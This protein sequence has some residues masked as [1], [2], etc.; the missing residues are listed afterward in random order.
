MFL[1][2]IKIKQVKLFS[3]FF[4]GILLFQKNM[5][6]L[7]KILKLLKNYKKE[8]VIAI[9]SLL[10]VSLCTSAIAFLVKPVLDDIFINKN[11]NMLY[12]I[13]VVVIIL[14]A[15][16]GI[17]DFT[18]TYMIGFICQKIV[19]DI[20]QQ[21]FS[22]IVNL[23]ME[24]FT[25]NSTGSII[26]RLL[27]DVALIQNT[28][29]NAITGVIKD[30]F[31]VISLIGVAFYRDAVLGSIALYIL[32]L[33]VLPVIK[34]GKKSKNVS[35]KGQEQAGS[36]TT[37]AHEIVTG[38][39][40]VKA[41]NM[42]DYEINRFLNENNTFLKFILKRL[43]YRAISS[44]TMEFIGGLAAAAIIWY[45]GY[46]V[47]QGHSTPG[48][49]FS[50]LTAIFMMYQPIK[51]LSRKNNQIQES[52][53]A[54]ERIYGVI[55]I[56][57][58]KDKGSMVFEEF[59]EKIEFK[60]V[61]FKYNETEDY[62]LKNISFTLPK[63][64]K[65]AIV[66]K[67]GSGKSTLAGLLPRFYNIEKGEILIDEINIEQYTLASL[68]A[69]I[70]V[71]TQ[72]TI[73]FNDTIENNIKY[74]SGNSSEEEIVQAAKLANAYDFIM[75][76]PEK[77]NTQIGEKG[78]RLS[79]G[80]KQRI[81]IARAFLKNAPILILD[82]AT[83]SL[84]TNSEKEVQKALEN[85]TANKTSIVIAHRLSTILDADKILVLKD[86]NIVEEG[87]HKELLELN[88]EYANLYRIQFK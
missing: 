10:V 41:F 40:V 88:G 70:A 19:T 63:G 84:D 79:G 47:I 20:R 14:Y 1:I 55:E 49:F 39:K 85:L 76:L 82:E 33:A 86:G 21:L 18:Q 56:D 73:L 12:Y 64:K 58:E 69:K 24:Y 26:A 80:E 15:V 6:S 71:V 35:K 48:N 57:C 54:A 60:N 66:G 2:Q 62:V 78:V 23:P 45:G 9:F 16:K 75:N 77:F 61:F 68:R 11:L 17:F 27:Y 52:I 8:I 34:L 81:A 51:G 67:S 37:S 42:Q 53:A 7:L 4:G 83:A 25:K 29:S 32:P 22:H 65:F 3:L 31:T 28:I 59:K 5:K 46:Q 13:P 43:K 38:I 36:L 72:D 87:T 30:I 50:F 44:P 74:G